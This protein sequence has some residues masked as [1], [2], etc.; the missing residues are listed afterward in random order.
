MDGIRAGIP[1]LVRGRP[2][3]ER[4]RP[5]AGRAGLEYTEG[6]SR[7]RGIRSF[8]ATSFLAFGQQRRGVSGMQ[9]IVNKSP[10]PKLAC[11]RTGMKTHGRAG[12]VRTTLS[13]FD[14]P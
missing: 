13:R 6:G 3:G 10:A 9:R 14:D 7:T 2:A 11:V 12:D 1:P 8:Q 4:V 5:I